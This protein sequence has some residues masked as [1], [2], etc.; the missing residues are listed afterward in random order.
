MY[1]PRSVRHTPFNPTR[2]E[3]DGAL[4]LPVRVA[5]VAV[6]VALLVEA[7]VVAVGKAHSSSR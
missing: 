1:Q 4:Q 5:V 7:L 6:P 3:D 2:A